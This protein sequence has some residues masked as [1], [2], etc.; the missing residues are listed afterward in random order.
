MAYSDVKTQFM[1]IL[2]RRDIT[3]SLVDTFMGFAI[4]RIHQEMRVPAMEKVAQLT[5]DGSSLLDVPSDL[6]EFIS[7]H[8]NDANNGRTKLTRTDLAT[9]L[10]FAAIQGQPIYYHRE[11]A[12]IYL[13]PY[14]PADQT[15]FV[16]YFADSTSLAA[17]TDTNWLTEVAPMLLVYAALTFAADYF[18]DDRIKL[19]EDRYVQIRDS[20]VNMGLQDEVV[21]ASIRPSFYMD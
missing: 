4:Q 8:V 13:G 21:N 5:T 16:H 14:P 17:D 1:A 19:F 7:V 12:Y 6:L 15:V 18:I 9:I 10:E 2:N 11:D 3:A 20:L